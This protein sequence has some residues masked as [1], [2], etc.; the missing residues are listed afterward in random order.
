MALSDKNIV[1]TPNI[2]SSTDDPKIVFTGANTSSAYAITLRAYPTNA[3]TL[4]FEGGAGQLFS[5]SNTMSGTIYSVNDVSGI[6]SIEVLDTGLV[7]IAQYSGNVA[8]GQSTANYKVD[9]NGSVN[10]AAYLVN[11]SPFSLPS[12]ANQQLNS[13]GVNTAASG[14]AGEIRA[15]GLITAYYSD[16][17][18]KT[19]LGNITN[20]IDK[21]K[22]LNGFYYEAN[23]TAQALGFR[24]KREVGVSAQEVQ[25][26]LPEIV[27]P[28]PI[29]EKYLTISYERLVPLLIEA[30]KEQ[31]EQIDELKSLINK[32]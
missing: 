28:A 4:S 18:L 31:Q 25:N 27:S 24:K 10:A 19:N 9:I 32:Q 2:S 20:A 30:I 16:E 5:I 6:P 8:I 26:I 3:G 13:L 23:E 17:N 1:I 11:G 22:S 21:V 15:T 12:T 7:K 29:D 14:T